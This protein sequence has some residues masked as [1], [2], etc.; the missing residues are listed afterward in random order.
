ML[1]L[2]RTLP[3]V[4]AATL[5]GGLVATL[6]IAFLPMPAIITAIAALG[7]GAL[8]VLPFIWPEIKTLATL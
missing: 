4:I 8:A 6:L 1:E 5:I 2:G 7:L 3:R